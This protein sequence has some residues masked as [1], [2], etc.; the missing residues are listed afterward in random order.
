MTINRNFFILSL[1][2]S[3]IIHLLLLNILP[4][5]NIDFK[6]NREKVID[7]KFIK[8]APKAT[9][10]ITEKVTKEEKISAY[11]IASKLIKEKDEIE[12][13]KPAVALPEFL[14]E[15]KIKLETKKDSLSSNAYD[16]SATNIEVVSELKKES[17]GNISKTTDE[18][19]NEN[20]FF[21][22]ESS[23]NRVRKPTFVPKMPEYSLTTDTK[24]K[25]KFYV[26]SKGF[27]T[28]ITFLTATD[29]YIEK[30]SKD[31]VSKLR[32]E[33]STAEDR[34]DEAIITLF[35]RVK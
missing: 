33:S 17:A 13:K 5:L 35:F 15:E 31:F 12:V 21:L 20:E 19:S 23:A 26:S 10:K 32:F 3:S 9:Q 4:S 24:V 30:I 7:V 11:D 16:P 1:L 34:R 27:P 29:P 22:I 2:V 8:I 18:I 6:E 14:S 25:I 28:E